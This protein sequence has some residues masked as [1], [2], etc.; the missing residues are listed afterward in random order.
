MGN[1]KKLIKEL[2]KLNVFKIM[3]KKTRT[4][5]AN[6]QQKHNTKQYHWKEISNSRRHLL[7]WTTNSNRIGEPETRLALKQ[8]KWV[9]K[10]S[11][12]KQSAAT[13]KRRTKRTRNAWRKKEQEKK[14]NKKNSNYNNHKNNN[15]KNN[16]NKKINQNNK[17]NGKKNTKKSW[18][19][20]KI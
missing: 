17:I 4:M 3:K 16:K 20:F 14:K 11:V 19:Q 7:R 5:K 1:K 13:T 10:I 15:N 6:Q 8:Q 9:N 12:C 18:I 2:N